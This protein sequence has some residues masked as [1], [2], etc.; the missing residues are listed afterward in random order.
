MI[1]LLPPGQK[2][3]LT[4]GFKQRLASVYIIAFATSVLLGLVLL[5]PSYF[6][7]DVR[8]ATAENERASLIN[9]DESSERE[10]INERL[11]LTKERLNALIEQDVRIPLYIVI[12]ELA[13]ASGGDVT[14]SNFG[15]TRRFGEEDSAFTISGN[16]QTR[17][18]L[19]SF[20]S[21][22]EANERITDVT[23]P[24]SSL[25]KDRDIDFSI[26]IEGQF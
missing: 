1:N 9:S 21:L 12:N 11:R 6:L 14:L 4:Q 7:V 13:E 19:L 23:L 20:R 22:L 15:Y 24:V 16:A 3:S 10:E 5:L 17:E 26:E 25:A 18:G 8:E 2:T